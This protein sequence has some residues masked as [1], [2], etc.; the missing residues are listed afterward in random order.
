M[1]GLAL[2][3]SPL[4]FVS[5]HADSQSYGL[6]TLQGYEN[7]HI[8]NI[9]FK[10]TGSV[11]I[12]GNATLVIE[13]STFEL[14]QNFDYQYDISVIEHGT[15]ILRNA[16]MQS[17][18]SFN[19]NIGEEATIVFESSMLKTSGT[20][21]IDGK[22]AFIIE[23][24]INS[25]ILV[26]TADTIFASSTTFESANAA[27]IGSGD[28]EITNCTFSKPITITEAHE[29]T[30]TNL[31]AP[32]ISILSG[33]VTLKRWVVF[34]LEDSFGVPLSNGKIEIYPYLGGG[35][36]VTVYTSES[37]YAIVSLPSDILN[38]SGGGQYHNYVGN[39]R[40]V[41]YAGGSYGEVNFSLPYYREGGQIIKTTYVSISINAMLPREIYFTPTPH[42]LLIRD[43]QRYVIEGGNG[44]EVAYLQEGN[45]R[46][47]EDGVLE[48]N[49]GMLSIMERDKR[50]CI[51]VEDNGS[52]ILNNAT[53]CGYDGGKLEI[54]L[55]D[56]AK[57]TMKDSKLLVEVLEMQD[58]S[59]LYSSGKDNLID[60]R[61]GASC[62]MINIEGIS[63]SKEVNVISG[64]VRACNATFFSNSTF[65]SNA[66]FT[67]VIFKSNLFLDGA[68]DLSNVSVNSITFGKNATCERKW[69]LNVKVINGG[70]RPVEGARV[71]LQK[72][73][74]LTETDLA[75]GITDAKGS[76]RFLV[77]GEIYAYGERIF[78][79]NYR[80]TAEIERENKLLHTNAVVTAANQ[81]K[82]VI[83]KFEEHVVPPFYLTVF[84]SN[85]RPI[86]AEQNSNVT[87]HGKVT[88]NG[89]NTPA[90]NVTIKATIL[91]YEGA[92][93]AIT[94]KNGMFSITILA[95]VEKKKYTINVTAIDSTLNIQGCAEPEIALNV[96]EK[97]E[98]NSFLPYSEEQIKFIL[99]GL[100]I[101]IA[102]IVIIVR[103]LSLRRYKTVYS[104]KKMISEEEA[105]SWIAEQIRTRGE[106]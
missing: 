66:T 72:I 100:L 12:R 106:K 45:I 55:F 47:F 52:L 7:V 93:Y 91:G 38:N 8:Q 1:L 18:K 53:V 39:Y 36:K 104:K 13:N 9:D 56:N 51:I 54:Y 102:A 65:R 44:S 4:V 27:S 77:L 15:L 23:S 35:E 11:L 49:N 80:V 105:L 86:T 101:G 22:N 48:V 57:I 41:A 96:V 43:H 71:I 40:A 31:T 3:L 14:I 6:L 24:K 90:E 79:G 89:G 83:L 33:K 84:I 19:I 74:N 95:P 63:L 78:A 69:W 70:D 59:M 94:D 5:M 16:N 87:L 21:R 42:D 34:T 46:I 26:L 25:G 64:D 32:S 10:H 2:M 82:I 75:E 97:K 37:G 88:Y 99:I 98:N 68:S 50:F 60:G 29:Y 81:N 17:V 28:V 61:L 30:F 62:R 67:D 103:H 58:N 92:W 20:L 73:D 85:R 76:V